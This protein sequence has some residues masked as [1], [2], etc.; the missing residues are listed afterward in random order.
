[1]APAPQNTNNSP[2]PEQ[3]H[4]KSLIELFKYV[5]GILTTLFAVI[6]LAVG[7][8]TYSNGTEMRASLKEEREDLNKKMESIE[9]ELRSKE[10]KL[11]QRQK[12]LEDFS[13]RVISQTQEN[14]LKQIGSV[15]DE[16]IVIARSQ[17]KS[18]IDDVFDKKNI[19]QFIE[20]V[21]Q[22]R[23]EP[24][25]QL[26]VDNNFKKYNA[27]VSNQVDELQFFMRTRIEMFNHGYME[28]AYAMDSLYHVTSNANIKV[29]CERT[30]IEYGSMYNSG[31]DS[32]EGS[33]KSISESLPNGPDGY[34]DLF[35]KGIDL[36][37]LYKYAT[38]ND[39]P[40]YNA[41]YVFELINKLTDK[42]IRAFD[43]KALKQLI[44]DYNKHP[45]QL[46]KL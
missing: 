26:L 18:S 8:M 30:L 2:S 9:G 39:I 23:I 46:K 19:D 12:E 13:M 6:G 22:R 11:V 24:K 4:Y 31:T 17:A 28:Y 14:A 38:D 36:N 7:Y 21:A 3:L 45:Y 16:S 35:K 10:D 5:I 40:M 1:M 20:Q 43:F 34:K 15:R 44:D 25:V 29:S 41:S 42:R 33:I 37:K 32:I 27:L